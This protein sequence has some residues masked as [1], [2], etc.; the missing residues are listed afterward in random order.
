MYAVA[1]LSAWIA[2]HVSIS[3]ASGGPATARRMPGACAN[4]TSRSLTPMT[5]APPAFRNSRLTTARLRHHP[6]RALNRRHDARV[7]PAAAQM[8]VH[9]GPNLRFGRRR[10]LR[11]QLG[12]F[13]D[14]PVVAVAAL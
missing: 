3:F 4:V 1:V 11:E 12:A 6:G 7:R 2:I 5:S 8:P 9:R 13:D 10:R 14:H